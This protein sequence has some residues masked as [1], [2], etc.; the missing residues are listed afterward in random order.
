MARSQ[1][2]GYRDISDIA[3]D[4]P[5]ISLWQYPPQRTST[6]SVSS[7]RAP[8]GASPQRCRCIVAYAMCSCGWVLPGACRADCTLFIALLPVRFIATIS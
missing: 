8:P 1:K 3:Q 5:A 7:R 6:H 2:P 4:I